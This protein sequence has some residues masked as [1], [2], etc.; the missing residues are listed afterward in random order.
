MLFSPSISLDEFAISTEH[1]FLPDGL[2]LSQ[3]AQPYFAPWEDLA[4]QLPHLI[5]TGQIRCLVDSLPILSPSRLQTEPEWR[6]AYV[7]LGFLTHA[8]IWG[9]KKP[10]D[11]LPP[12]ISKP[13]LEISAHLELPAC[14]TY[15]ALTLWN[16]R[17]SDPKSELINPDTLSLLTS[18][19]GTRDEEWFIVI[20]VAIEARGAKLVPLMLD[21]IAAANTHDAPRLAALLCRF[22]DGLRELNTILKRMYEHC[23]PAVFFHQLRP[24]LAGSK[25]MST[26]GLPHGVFYDIGDGHGEWHQYSGGSNAQSSLIQTFD[27]FLGV[28]HSATGEVRPSGTGYIQEMRKYMPAP[29]RRF[30]E[31]LSAL[32]TV[33]PFIMSSHADSPAKEAYNAAVLMLS[34]FRD[35]HIQIVSRYIITPARNHASVE[36]ARSDRVNLASPS[37]GARNETNPTGLY[38]TG[39]TSLIPFLKQ[40]RDTTKAATC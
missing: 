14:A 15:A 39:G 12:C 34:A 7:V 10:K 33:R 35:T 31:T 16:Y 38:G 29:H 21:A 20:S 26:A 2:P 24:F 18:F 4:S 19:T 23:A 8:Y 36:Q 6:R 25:N 3:L 40:T 5:Q 9:G 1:G 22:T 30:L 17:T 11:V 28:N 27:I 32:S 13:F 37:A